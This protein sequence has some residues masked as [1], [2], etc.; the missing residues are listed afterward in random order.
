MFTPSITREN[1]RYLT[2]LP[3]VTGV[4]MALGLV[5]LSSSPAGASTYRVYTANAASSMTLNANDG[6]CSLAEAI[7][8]AKGNTI[9]NCTDHNSGSS[10]QRIELLESANRPFA[11]NHF[12]LT[13]PMTLTRQGILIRIFGSG[14]FIDSTAYSAFIVSF[15]SKAFFERVTLS[16][17]AGSGG[18][19]LIENYGDLGFYG[20]TLRNGDVTG[21]H[22]ATGRGGAIFNGNTSN[23]LFPAS[24]SFAENSV[25]TGNKA[26]KGGGIYNDAGI[27]NDLSVTISNNSATLAGGGIYNISTDLNTAEPSNGRIIATGL[28]VTGNSARTGGGIFNRAW[29][30]LD[31]STITGNS[32]TT[33]GSSGEICTG[34]ASCDGVGGGIVNAH[35]SAVGGAPSGSVTR[36]NLKGSSLS[37]NTASGRGGGIYSVGLLEFGGN[38]INGNKATDGAAAYITGPTD[39][40]QQ[41]CNFYG[42]STVGTTTFNNN[43]V[44]VNGVCTNGT[45]SYSILS[46][47]N[48]GRVDFRACEIKGTPTPG[49]TTYLTATGNSSSNYCKSAVVDPSY[50]CPQPCGGSNQACCPGTP[51]RCNA[52]LTCF[53]PSGGVPGMAYC[54]TP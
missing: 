43:C 49:Q 16:N 7:E 18:G 39:G 53:L 35:I 22:H 13:A 14:G 50:R 48:G 1:R 36:F 45:T 38:A 34:S 29:I 8:H 51:A 47:S 52:G 5:L 32:T 25:I 27:I 11:T 4:S 9:Y 12:T 46:G 17:T 33:S 40:M 37:N 42:S 26:R 19:R 54:R 21:A 15:K 24:I 41:Y 10:E 20:V 6:F 44:T 2:R 23:G 3:I 30:I 28:S 31:G